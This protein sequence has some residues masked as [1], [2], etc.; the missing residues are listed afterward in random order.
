MAK[1]LEP[2]EKMASHA[3]IHRYQ[4]G[5]GRRGQKNHRKLRKPSP[6]YVY[7]LNKELKVT[8]LDGT[9]QLNHISD[10]EE[11]KIKPTH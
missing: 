11:H 4:V 6:L 9:K 8:K 2:N 1:Q 3:S 7:Q 5:V 10:D